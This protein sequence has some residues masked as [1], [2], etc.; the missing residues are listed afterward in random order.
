MGTL[1]F[2]H[3]G[4]SAAATPSQLLLHFSICSSCASVIVVLLIVSFQLYASTELLLLIM[5]SPSFILLTPVRKE[6]TTLILSSPPPPPHPT[7]KKLVRFSSFPNLVDLSNEDYAENGGG[8]SP[9]AIGFFLVALP[10][11]NA[12]AANTPT[13]RT[14]TRKRVPESPPSSPRMTLYPRPLKKVKI[15]S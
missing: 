5:S 11:G 2:F 3:A 1:S 7:T 8:P 9:S 12:A 15:F 10:F 4:F 6:L 13:T 14:D